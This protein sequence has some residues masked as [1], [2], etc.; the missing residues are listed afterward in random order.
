MNK[1][2]DQRFATSRPHSIFALLGFVLGLLVVSATANAQLQQGGPAMNV[3][4]A[5]A[6]ATQRAELPDELQAVPLAIDP[7]A[8]SGRQ[9][10]PDYQAHD[11]SLEGVV[12]GYLVAGSLRLTAEKVANNRSS[13]TSGPLRISLWAT[14]YK[15]SYGSTLTYR[16][17]Y[18]QFSQ[19]LPA[20]YYF[21]PVDRTV[22]YGGNPP[23]GTYY[24]TMTVD[25]YDG[26]NLY[27]DGYSY[28][29]LA[30]FTTTQT[31]GPTC[32]AATITGQPQPTTA[33]AGN[34]TVSV[35]AT[36]TAPLSY[37]WYAGASGDTSNPIFGATFATQALSGITSSVFVWARV[38]NCG[39]SVNSVAVLLSPGNTGGTCTPNAT[40]GCLLN[41]RFRATLRYRSSFDNNPAD[42]TAFLKSVTG[43]AAATYETAF[44]YFNNANNIEMVIKILDQGNTNGSGQP[45]I[46]VLFGSATP[47]RTELTITDTNNGAVR[48]YT[49]DFGSQRGQTDFAAFVK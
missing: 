49:S 31:F 7:A 32:V 42:A 22:T 39:G 29:D 23:N 46:A 43:F 15:P 40:T 20:G 18:Y 48:V 17:G 19:P 2:L 10:R 3:M 12:S 13:G 1:R 33:S 26:N 14:T 45:T 9:V 11:L 16:L 25:E 28:H 44:F 21:G 36:G 6:L 38:S 37:Q 27:L 5:E 34:A 30:V 24:I 41:N 35:T 47:L 8:M 4:P